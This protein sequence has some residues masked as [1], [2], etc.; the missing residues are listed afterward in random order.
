LARAHLAFELSDEDEKVL[1]AADRVLKLRS[2]DPQ[3]TLVRA[4]VSLRRKEY[5]RAAEGFRAALAAL[6]DDYLANE[7]LARTLEFDGH[8]EDALMRY[9]QTLR[10]TRRDWQ[11]R[12][13]HQG[14]ARVL[15]RL[16]RTQDARLAERAARE[17]GLAG[18]DH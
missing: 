3:A 14:R 2:G 16:G 11:R 4:A 8:V 7:G 6:P 15:D 18:D 5:K 13:I 1:Q 12:E 17:A 9:D 10:L